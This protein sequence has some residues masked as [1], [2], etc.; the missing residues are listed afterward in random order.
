LTKDEL[1]EKALCCNRCGTCRGVVQDEVP[2]VAFSTQCQCSM[3]LFGA[4]EP[5]GLMY[6]ARG[7][8][9]G[10]LKWN[11]DL[12][13]ILYSCTMCGYCDDFCQRGYR[14]TPC[15]TIL[16][17]L[18]VIIPEKLKPAAIKKQAGSLAVPR[19]TKLGVL[20]QYGI[21]DASA[22]KSPVVLFG[23]NTI[24]SNAAKLE[25]IGF[26]I[27]QSGKKV[28]CFIS[29]PL[30]PVSAALL[31]GGFRKEL[32]SAIAVI[33]AQL[34]AAG[35]KT[36]IVYNP[37]S[38]SVLKRFSRSGVEFISITRFCADMLK[39]KKIKAKKVKLGKVTFQDPCHLGRFSKEYAAPREIMQRLGLDVVEMWRTRDNSLCCGA[40][41][42]VNVNRP[43]LA[44]KY[45][46]NRWQEAKATGAQTLLTACAFCN[47]NLRKGKPR[48][49]A[50]MDI[51]SVVAQALG[52]A[53]K[54]AR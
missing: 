27:Q 6:L 11:E 21:A 8:A 28:G 41:G 5:S 32:E 35:V 7:I 46:D 10:D 16:E 39:S 54:E 18:R 33:D 14:H 51:T 43:D 31:S 23:D 22:G 52:Y 25:E 48:N 50:V 34:E 2:D 4:Y 37:E 44:K 15:D 24:I 36:V 53:G 17:E 26:I 13:K 38:L 20:A 1:L 40:G 9:Q 30:P 3:T 19:T 49:V 12:A 47:A 45:A 29:K 42:G